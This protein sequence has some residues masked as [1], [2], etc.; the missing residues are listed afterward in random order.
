LSLPWKIRDHARTERT[1]ISASGSPSSIARFK[2]WSSISSASTGSSI[3]F[4]APAA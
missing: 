2:P 3:Q 1:L 4:S